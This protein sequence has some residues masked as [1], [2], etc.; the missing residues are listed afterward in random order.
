MKNLSLLLI[1]VLSFFSFSAFAQNEIETA[2]AQ[3]VEN[4]NLQ[5]VDNQTI[6][7]RDLNEM[8]VSS[9]YLSPST[10]LYHIYFNQRFKE[11]EVY[12]AQLNIVLK[13]KKVAYA[14]PQFVAGLEKMGLLEKPSVSPLQAVQ[15]TATHLGLTS[16]NPDLISEEKFSNGA[17]KKAIFSE[18]SL[19]EKPISAQL[20]W[21]PNAEKT[22]VRLVWN[23]N[24]EVPNKSDWWNVRLDAQTGEILEQNNWV[25]HCNFDT[26]DL[27]CSHHLSE[28]KEADQKAPL[29]MPNDYVVFDLPLESPKHGA[30]TTVNAPYTRFL[31]LG[32]GP[33]ATNG[34]HDNGTTIFTHTQGNN[35]LAQ[36]DTD[37]SNA[38]AGNR[39]NP[40]NFDFDYP[41]TFGL[42]TAAGNQNAAIVNLFYWNNLIHDVLYKFGFDEP[43]GN[44]QS[45]NMARGGLGNDHVL[46]DA[47]DGGGT[48]NANFSSG[49]DGAN[50]RMQMYLWS[51]TGGSTIFTVNS[52]AVVAANYAVVESNFSTNNKLTSVLSGDLVLVDDAGAA[53]T[54]SLGCAI[55]FD[56]AASIAGKIAVID[57]GG[58]GCN[59]VL[60]AKNA[61]S[62]GAIGVLVINNVTTTPTAMGGTDNTIIIPAFM[63]SQA[64]GNL[65]KA[66]LNAAQTVNVTFTPPTSGYQPDGDFDNGIIAHE[67]GHGWSNRLTGGPANSSCLAN[68]EQMGEG[69]SDFLGLMLTTDWAAQTATIA[70]ANISRGIGTYAIGQPITGGGIR[71]FPYS[72]NKAAINN[73]VTYGAVANTSFSAPHGIG[74]IWCTML[75]DMAWEIIFQDNQIVSDVYNTSNLVGNVAAFKLVNE[76]LRLQKC[77]PSF[78]DGRNAILKADE[79]LFNGKYKC[80]IWKAF[81]RRG[82]GVNASSGTSSADRVVVE[83]FD[84][85]SG[86]SIAK[87]SNLASAPEGSNVTYTLTATC[88]CS[89]EI[90]ALTDVLP[91]SLTYVANSATNG[92][93][94]SGN[95]L[96]W[97]AQ[98]FNPAEVKTYTFQATTGNVFAPTVTALND[99]LDGSTP[100]GTWLNTPVSGTTNFTTS[101]TFTHSGATALFAANTTVAP[102][103]DFLCT[104]GLDYTLTGPAILSFWHRFNTEADWDGGVV[105]ISINGGTSWIDL[106]Q[107]ITIYPYNGSIGAASRSGF[108]G[109]SNGWKKSEINLSAFCGTTA[110]IRFR[111]INDDNTDCA[112]AGNCGWYIDDILLTTAS[113]IKNEASTSSGSISSNCIEVTQGNLTLTLNAKTYLAS[114]DIGTGLM[115]DYVKTLPSFPNKDP[116]FTTFNTNFTHV[117]NTIQDSTTAT[118]LAA[119]GNNAIV[120]W[121]FL[122]LRTGLSGSTTIVRTKAALMQKDGDIVDMDGISPV[123]F[124]NVPTGS[125]YVAVRHRN[126]LGFRTDA[127]IAL[128]ATTPAIDFTNNSIVLYGIS[129]LASASATIKTMNG[130]DS[131]SDGSID[132]TDSAVWEL[133]NGSFD[134]YFMNADYNLDGSVDGTDSAIWELNNGKYQELD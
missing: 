103:N 106:G 99:D 78:V 60:K 94:L 84:M 15:L 29:A 2:K 45:S 12:N 134:D 109:N 21:L 52:P 110:K 40:S 72:Y 120:D 58:T 20:Y 133:Q 14:N 70:S 130:G 9:A 124:A 59:F 13:N 51:S 126:H 67:Y 11:I 33:G 55:P 31:P 87:T 100:N 18:Y 85:P 5:I 86:V 122:E 129:P 38:T 19:T 93:S 77:S 102:A 88:A 115:D 111:M 66:Q 91:S 95:T 75:W 28:A 105:E 50:G 123:A 96:T 7:Q 24:I 116:Y 125:Y 1:G 43:S 89:P 48:N 61:Q 71:P 3:L 132:G 104:S 68:T 36:D 117:N 39:P 56:N 25:A 44:Y 10:G 79:L 128:S 16:F 97:A 37:A 22:S 101:S 53:V 90:I 114:Y 92:G 17:I 83:N 54:T 30:R 131:T 62:A 112:S 6:S 74:S 121:V 57:R 49:V 81:A 73:T 108:S 35:V 64:N 23:V 119:T 4:K 69:W 65:L 41:Y 42:A 47:Q 98:N 8:S 118:V 32:S 76:G 80:S 34:W 127:P 107:Y 27:T 46:A 63:I 26:P 82:L 113:G